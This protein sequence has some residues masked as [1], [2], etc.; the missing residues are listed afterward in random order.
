MLR[1]RE[2]WEK[3]VPAS[4]CSLF[5][6]KVPS[7]LYP[8]DLVMSWLLVAITDFRNVSE[9]PSSLMFN[10][11]KKKA[12]RFRCLQRCRLQC[13]G[14]SPG[15]VWLQPVHC[16]CTPGVGLWLLRSWQREF[17]HRVSATA[18]LSLPFSFHCKI[19][20][21]NSHTPPGVRRGQAG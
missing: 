5:L 17:Y 6:Q 2:Q 4:G 11:A 12:A 10:W 16:A 14:V 19:S 20:K 1:Q 13:P 18:W 7:L 15:S 9:K 21:T 3:R 8:W